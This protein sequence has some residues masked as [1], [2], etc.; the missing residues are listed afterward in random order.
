MNAP[1][2]APD[3]A[4]TESRLARLARRSLLAF[5]LTFIAS[6][7]VVYP[8]MSQRIPN[9]YFFLHGIHVHH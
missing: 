2:S 1:T 3:G 4:P 9:P 5:V 7:S 6:R 8:I